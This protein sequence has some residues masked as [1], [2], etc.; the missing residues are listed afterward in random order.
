MGVIKLRLALVEAEYSSFA[1]SIGD[2][3]YSA[4][5]CFLVII[6]CD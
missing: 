3:S 4:S 5:I 1:K 2:P 6:V